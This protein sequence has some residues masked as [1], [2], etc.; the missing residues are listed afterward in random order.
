MIHSRKSGGVEGLFLRPSDRDVE[1]VEFFG[2]HRRAQGLECFL[3]TGID[4]IVEDVHGVPFAA[5]GAMHGAEG[6]AGLLRAATLAAQ[7]I[8]ELGN[9]AAVFL[10]QF[11]LQGE[12]NVAAVTVFAFASG[13]LF[14]LFEALELFH[15]GIAHETSLV[16]PEAID[17][18]RELELVGHEGIPVP[19]G[20][21]AG[22]VDGHSG[23]GRSENFR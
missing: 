20:A 8:E 18:E 1:N 23:P 9:G 13:V 4:E 10:H 21:G 7:E 12:F 16:V 3:V 11:D 17:V 5:L 22:E 14:H 6:E 15:V 2:A 19:L